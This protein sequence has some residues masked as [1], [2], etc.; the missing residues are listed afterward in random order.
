M[1]LFSDKAFSGTCVGVCMGILLIR[2]HAP[3]PYRTTVWLSFEWP[4]A[5]CVPTQA[6]RPYVG[7][8]DLLEVDYDPLE[9]YIRFGLN[10][11]AARG[12]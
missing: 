5:S 3:P 6:T 9:G 10:S 11:L 1:L 2:S 8:H 7:A 12:C 4:V